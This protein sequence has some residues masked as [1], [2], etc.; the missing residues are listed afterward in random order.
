MTENTCAQPAHEGYGPAFPTNTANDGSD[1][2]CYPNYGMSLRDYFAAKALQGFLSG[3]QTRGFSITPEMQDK[4]A[5]GMY[6]MADAMLKARGGCS[7][8]TETQAPEGAQAASVSVSV[9][10][11]M[12]KPENTDPNQ[13]GH[14]W[15]KGWNAAIRQAMDYA[16]AS[17][18]RALEGAPV[19]VSPEA[20]EAWCA[21]NCYPTSKV[22]NARDED[23]NPV[24]TDPRTHAAW[25]AVQ[26]L[27]APAPQA[28]PGM[29]LVP[30]E[31]TFAM[32][33]A[34]HEVTDQDKLVYGNAGSRWRAMLAAAPQTKE[35]THDR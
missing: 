3:F 6:S 26:D 17:Q 9:L 2:A 30:R 31:P 20:F 27:A 15:A 1:G 8:T 23:G 19:V 32:V 14:Q 13:Q 10:A 11:R 35:P 12:S 33:S 21:Q 24:Y 4:I 18:P 25:F 28:A 5:E 29:V 34:F 16:L 7:M 22:A